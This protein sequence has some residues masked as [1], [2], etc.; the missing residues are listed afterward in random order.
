MTAEWHSITGRPRPYMPEFRW[1]VD[2][3]IEVHHG[4]H[5]GLVPGGQ[6]DFVFVNRHVRPD[7][8]VDAKRMERDSPG[9]DESPSGC[10][11]S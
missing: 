9:I 3:R 10:A 8:R 11:V 7:V 6:G 2:W 4:K 5:D 1:S